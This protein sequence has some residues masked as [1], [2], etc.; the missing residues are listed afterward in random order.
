[1]LFIIAYFAEPFFQPGII[2][3]AANDVAE[4]KG[5]PYFSAAGNQARDSWEGA[6]VP[7]GQ[8]DSKGCQ[9]HDFSNQSGNADVKQSLVIRSRGTLVF[10]W[11]DPFFSVSGPPGAA[12]DMD[13]IIY[14]ASDNVIR[15]FR[16][17]QT[18]F[19][20]VLMYQNIFSNGDITQDSTIIQVSIGHCSAPANAHE[21]G[22]I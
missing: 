4:L 8:F 12:T 1:M 19:D 9:L 18:G 22:G 7:S 21:M 16:A 6:F 14:D 15:E 17:N 5:I 2:A 11:D 13:L 3:Q 20:P 10:Q